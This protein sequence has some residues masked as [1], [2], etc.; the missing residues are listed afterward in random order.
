M[1]ASVKGEC[2]LKALELLLGPIHTDWRTDGPLQGLHLL[3]L[4]NISSFVWLP[5]TVVWAKRL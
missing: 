5:K 2:Y 4:L 3:P 1:T